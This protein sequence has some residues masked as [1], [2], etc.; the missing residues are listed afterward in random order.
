MTSSTASSC[1]WR[2]VP[3]R[4]QG[5]FPPVQGVRDGL[6]KAGRHRD[7]AYRPPLIVDRQDALHG[8]IVWGVA[9]I[10]DE[11]NLNRREFRDG[12]L[13]SGPDQIPIP[14]QSRFYRIELDQIHELLEDETMQAACGTAGPPPVRAR[15]S[16]SASRA[17]LTIPGSEY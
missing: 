17:R 3:K 15:L 6:E 4:R 16:Q 9:G 11:Q 7:V 14:A 13:P 12:F 1:K 10:G 2:A 5:H 8:F